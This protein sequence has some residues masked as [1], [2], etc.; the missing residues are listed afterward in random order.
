MLEDD[1]GL[2]MFIFGVFVLIIFALMFF[3]V[4]KYEENKPCKVIATGTGECIER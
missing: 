3:T 4:L 2:G 1:G